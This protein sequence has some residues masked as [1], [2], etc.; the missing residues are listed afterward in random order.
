MLPLMRNTLVL[1]QRLEAGLR[2]PT[3]AAMLCLRTVG[4]HHP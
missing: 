1:G 4:G 3:R 2:M